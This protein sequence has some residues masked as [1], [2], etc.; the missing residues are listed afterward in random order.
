M[1]KVNQAEQNRPFQM[2]MWAPK[3]RQCWKKGTNMRCPPQRP[4]VR[5]KIYGV[6]DT[7][8]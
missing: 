8:L 3:P 2:P 1:N 5:A 6:R 7:D 4:C